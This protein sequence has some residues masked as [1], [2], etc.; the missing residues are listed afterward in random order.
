MEKGKNTFGIYTDMYKSWSDIF[1]SWSK[2]MTGGGMP[3]FRPSDMNNWF[4]P[5]QGYFGDWNRIYEGFG[6]TMA[7]FP[8]P[9]ESVNKYSR[10]LMQ[11]INSYVKIYDTWIRS[12]DKIGRKQFEVAQG[13]TTGKET[14]IEDL[15]DIINQSYA[16]ISEGI[17]E[18]LKGM[19]FEEAFKGADEINKALKKFIDSFPEEQKQAKEVFQT[20][21]SSY[22]KI[23]NSWTESMIGSSRSFA[24]MLAKG[25]I[26][27]DAY[28]NM[29]NTYGE[30]AKEAVSA[31]LGPLS[32]LAPDY[33]DM[34]DDL[35]DWANKYFDLLAAWMGVPLKLF[36]GIGKSST[37][38]YTFADETFRKGKVKSSQEYYDSWSE[39][40]KKISADLMNNVQF[41]ATLPRFVTALTDYI[42]STNK[43]YQR[44]LTP[45][46]PN[47]GD[48]EKVYSTIEDLKDIIEKGSSTAKAKSSKASS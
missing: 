30:A 47:K 4:K 40:Y 35:T 39:F 23:I 28:N 46:F 44:V 9:Y 1:N 2:S 24:D 20:F 5:F 38:M 11:G 10:V 37:E 41:F 29:V 19:P 43:V 36:Q 14:N 18:S 15:F 25:E 6:Q 26:S 22:I 32:A 42:K 17:V 7:G 33:K 34:V 12:L 13:I 31:L 8:W 16:E 3:L 45:S 21:C 27:A 48:M